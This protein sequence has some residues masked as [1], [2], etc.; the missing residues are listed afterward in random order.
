MQNKIKYLLVCLVFLPFMVGAQQV[1]NSP[2]SSFGIG[3]IH[4]DDLAFYQG[5]SG[6]GASFMDPYHLNIKNPSSYAFLRSAAYELGVSARY[7]QIKDA[8]NKATGWNGNLEYIALGFPLRNPINASIDP[9]KRDVKMGMSFILKPHSTVGYNINSE[10]VSPGLGAY[11]NNF[12]GNGGL[13]KFMWGNALQYKNVSFGANIG[14]LFGNINFNENVFFTEIENVFQNRNEID[15]NVN[16]FIWDAGFSYNLFLNKAAYEKD[17]SIKIKRLTFGL[18]GNS[19]QNFNT[20]SNESQSVYFLGLATQT[21]YADFAADTL[22][23]AEGL[24]GKGTLPAEIGIGATY[25]SDSKFTIGFNYEYGAWSKYKNS[26][27]NETLLDSWKLSIG[28]SYRPDAKSFNNYFKRVS[29]KL[30]VFYQKDP[31]VIDNIQISDTGFNLG[32]SFPFYYQRKISHINAA[33]RFG[34]KGSATPIQELYGRVTVGFTFNDDEW[35]IKRK[36]N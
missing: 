9:I 35:F 17:K 3:N 34:V 22:F 1:D 32:A 15:Y 36:Y 5:F 26:V 12:E 30:G 19:A 28:G 10:G 27:R 33:F 11:Q 6:Q 23:F 13:F 16:G 25:Y 21:A 8:T 14:Y 24:A 31:Q 18:Y 29:Y 7:F 4:S 20:I 2:F